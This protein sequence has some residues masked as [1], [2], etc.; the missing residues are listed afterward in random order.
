MKYPII[1]FIWKHKYINIIIFII[2]FIISFVLA[3][4]GFPKEYT[5]YLSILPPA[6][7]LTAG[8]ASKFGALGRVAGLDLGNLS[9][10]SPEIYMAILNSR[11]L[12]E[13]LLDTEFTF[14]TKGKTRKENLIR[15]FKIEGKSDLEINEKALKK[16]SDEVVHTSINQVDQILTLSVTTE[17]NILSSLV[18][19]KM[20][21]LLNEIVINDVQKEYRQKLNY[22]ENRIDEIQDS[23]KYAEN[24]LKKFL[25][26]NI[27]PTAPS[28]QIQQLRLKRDLELQT[29]LFI[30][31]RKQLEI[32]IADNM[33]NMSEVK[34]LDRA[35]PAYRK[36]R[37]KRILLFITFF[38]LLVFIHLAINYS[39]LLFKGLKKELTNIET[40][41]I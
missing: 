13:K 32:F 12:K 35:E 19:N 4:F 9:S 18:A 23:L 15:F 34:I 16:L 30:E 31:F 17:N 38:S 11:K 33:I 10:Q 26:S 14:P 3:F 2:I 40:K 36:S 20:L 22:I 41:I 28:F 37:P 21:D 1:G 8:L 29:G 25:E 7:N 39:F 5:S 27:N 24:E 6:Q